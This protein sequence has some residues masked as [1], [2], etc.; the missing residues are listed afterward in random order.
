M[1]HVKS[2][3]TVLA[4]IFWAPTA[5][6]QV[7]SLDARVSLSVVEQPLSEVVQF[8]RDKSGA[9]IVVLEG[10]DNLVND[11]QVTDI[12]WRDALEYAAKLA[13]CVVTEER[14]GVLTVTDPVRV[15]IEFND[16]DINDIITT[17]GAVSGANIIVSPSV[18]GTLRVR[19]T[20]V[21]WRDALEEIVKTRGYVVVED[22]PGI[23]RV[24][25]P[26]SLEEQKVTRGYQLRFVRPRSAIV[27][28]L[29]SEFMA[30]K[31]EPPV[32]RPSEHFT[33]LNAMR[34]ALSGEGELD[35]IDSQN[36]IIVRDTT[37]VHEALQEILRRIDVEPTQVFIDA[38]FVSSSNGDLLNLGVDFG[39]GGPSISATG[40]AI[41]IELP[42]TIGDGGFEDS[43]IADVGGNGPGLN[44][45]GADLPY[46]VIIPSVIYGS[47]SFTGVQATLRMLQ[48]DTSTEVIQAP[49]LVTLDGNPA[50]IFVG[51]TVRYAEAKSEQGQAGG[52]SLSVLEAAGSP[53]EVGFQLLV[54][55]HVI[56]GTK[57]I[58]MEVIPKETS[59]SGTS[60]NSTLAP[61]GFDVFTIGAAGL[62]GSIALP[63]TRSST[64]VT[65]ML[66]E[67][68]QTAVIGGLT[69]E[70][71]T[72]VAS[73]VPY[74]SRIPVLGEL[75]KYRS[76]SREKR[77]LV[78]FITPHL[79]HSAEDAEF[80]LQQELLRRRGK[81]KD[82]LDELLDPNFKSE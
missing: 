46:K 6:A 22:R 52:L 43:F 58:M 74:L 53:V 27:P 30:G 54:V 15:T 16:Q 67:D 35:Y 76:E 72:K 38:K 60:G 79:V 14:S 70:T 44:V 66:L 32:G 81:L 65:Q 10:G 41:P 8:L 62:Q 63:R 4:L 23:L 29:K 9:N 69:T 1:K 11:L 40:S 49:K 18:E 73:R 21:P 39:D 36:M 57:K 51:E 2:L 55:P 19:L 64:V 75:F 82:E 17:I 42:F 45:E 33:V 47:L 13:G 28:I 26:K 68:G 56:P 61:P 48:R 78:I 50:T 34:K 59:L 3:V 37:Q 5:L 12:F 20:N 80:L 24:V 71:E 7:P 25:D 77:S 31:I